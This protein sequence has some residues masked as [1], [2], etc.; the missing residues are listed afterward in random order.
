[1]P[2]QKETEEFGIRL[3]GALTGAVEDIALEVNFNL[4]VAP[5]TPFPYNDLVPQLPP[6]DDLIVGGVS[7]P[8]WVIGLLAE[9]DAD[10]KGD[11]KA[12]TMARNVRIFGEGNVCYSIPMVIK[13]VLDRLTNASLYYGARVS[14]TTRAPAQNTQS[15][16]PS[17]AS[18]TRL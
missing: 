6:V 18:I 2:E 11:S 14:R 1:M 7:L 9:K 12:K 16:C 10:K 13:G 17:C 4:N 15:A 5:D 3:A 8:P